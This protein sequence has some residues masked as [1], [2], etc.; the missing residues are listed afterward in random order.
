MIEKPHMVAEIIMEFDMPKK[1]YTDEQKKLLEASARNSQVGKSLNGT[2]K[3]TLV[4][5]Y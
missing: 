2:T 3:Q 5:N 1:N 4:F